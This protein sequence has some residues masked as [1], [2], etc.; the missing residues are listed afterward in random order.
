MKKLVT[1]ALLAAWA[2]TAS[3]TPAS[4]GDE[5]M[6]WKDEA[7]LASWLD[8]ACT[9][10][11]ADT[12]ETFAARPTLRVSDRG[13]I[14]EIL[15]AEL[16]DFDERAVTPQAAEE[17]ANMLSGALMAKYAP[18]ANVVHVQ[19]DAIRL[20]G[21]MQPSKGHLEADHVRVLLLHEATHALDFTTHQLHARMKACTSASELQAVGAI[22]EGHAQFVAWRVS[23]TLDRE[24]AF[25]RVTYGITGEPEDATPVMRMAMAAVLAAFRFPYEQG[26]AFFKAVFAAQGLDGVRAALAEPPSDPAW[27]EEPERWLD[28]SKRA[29]SIDAAAIIGSAAGL[30]SG[31]HWKPTQAA[32]LRAQIASQAGRLPEERRAGFL[33]GFDSGAAL[34][35]QQDGVAGQAILLALGFATLEDAERYEA[36]GRALLDGSKDL[37][38][39]MGLTFEERERV[40][41]I[42]PEGAWPGVYAER[43]I[44]QGAFQ[45]LIRV[46]SMRRGRVVLE[47][48]S[49]NVAAVDR[50]VLDRALIRLVAAIDAPEEAAKLPALAPISVPT[51]EGPEEDTEEVPGDEEPEP[52]G[53]DR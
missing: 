7:E 33:T 5:P 9:A 4:A 17:S 15:L 8:A 35:A 48:V 11:E 6:P 2:L 30:F 34:V 25:N 22:S 10:V 14:R 13:T 39:A 36:D 47:L 46:M 29:T 12:G 27:V 31:E 38:E 24:A 50:A 53:A 20:V 26:L 21:R 41:G 42:G 23:K 16:K 52:A 18:D 3:P 43:A 49:M 1:A 32:V 37:I 44:G 19:P 40:E 45:Q 51:E 28:P